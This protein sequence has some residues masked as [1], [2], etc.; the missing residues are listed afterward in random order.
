MDERAGRARPQ[1]ARRAARARRPRGAAQ[2]APLRGHARR[3]DP[4]GHALLLHAPPREPGEVRRRLERGRRRRREGPPRP[5]RVVGGRERRP[6]RVERVLGRGEGRVRQEGEQ[7]GRGDAARHGRRD[8]QRLG[9]GRHRGRQVRPGVVD[10]RRL[11]VLLHEAARGPEGPGVGASG[12]G[13]RPPAPDRD[14]P[15]DRHDREREARRPDDVPERRSDARRTLPLP[16]RR[17]RLDV[18]GRLVPR[19]G[20]ESGRDGLDAA[21]RG[22]QGPLQRRHA[23]AHALRPDGRRRAE[24]PRLRGRSRPAR[25]RGVEGDRPRAPRRGAPELR[26]RRR[27][28]RPRVPEERVEPPRDPQPRRHA[29]AR[30]SPPRHRVGEQPLRPGRRGR[31]VLLVHVVH[32]ADVDLPDVREDRRDALYLPGQ[33]A[34]GPSPRTR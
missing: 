3:A 12:L 13:G 25:A 6:R 11:R 34:R 23:R 29:R 17:A 31:G 7:L 9:R 15:E 30:G 2:G 32:D 1:G 33:G 26:R 27:E 5:E 18:D 8:G 4:P 22:G 14:G 10:A 20:E 28:A 24:G 16:R 19:P 21:R